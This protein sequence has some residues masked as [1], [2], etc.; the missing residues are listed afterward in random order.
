MRIHADVDMHDND[1][2]HVWV[3]GWALHCRQCTHVAADSEP[4]CAQCD[5][6]SQ[7]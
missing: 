3:T 7:Q 2:L 4:M 6:L 5:P 1:E